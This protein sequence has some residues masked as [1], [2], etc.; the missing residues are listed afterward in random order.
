MF[1][2]LGF[3]VISITFGFLSDNYGLKIML[4]AMGM[5]LLLF[6]IIIPVIIKGIKT[7]AC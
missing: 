3:V 6:T 4:L 5:V 2:R 1:S 7:K